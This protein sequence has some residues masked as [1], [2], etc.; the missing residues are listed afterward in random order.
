[1]RDHITPLRADDFG[2]LGI[3]GEIFDVD[4][5]QTLHNLELALS[6]GVRF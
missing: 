2:A 5:D 3:I 4:L 6:V 1:V